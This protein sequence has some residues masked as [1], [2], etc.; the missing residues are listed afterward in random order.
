MNTRLRIVLATD[1][2]DPSGMGEHMLTLGRALQGQFDVTLAAIDGIQA[3]LL[4]RA[5]R[6]GV[7]SKASMIM[8]RSNIG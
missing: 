2:V 1:S 6:R 3:A 8:R 5:A 4:P 7:R